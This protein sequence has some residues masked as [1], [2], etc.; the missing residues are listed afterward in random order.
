MKRLTF[1]EHFGTDNKGDLLEKGGALIKEIRE[2]DGLT[3]AQFQQKMQTNGVTRTI[4][5]GK[6]SKWENGKTLPDVTVQNYII[7]RHNEKQFDS[8]TSLEYG[9]DLPPIVQ[10][11]R[12]VMFSQLYHEALV[13]IKRESEIGVLSAKQENVDPNVWPFLTML[14]SLVHRSLGDN[15]SALE[16]IESPAGEITDKKLRDVYE[17]NRMG[18][19]FFAIQGI[20]DSSKRNQEYE[21]IASDLRLLMQRWPNMYRTW[22]ENLLRVYSR[23]DDEARFTALYEELSQRSE[24]ESL[25]TIVSNEEDDDFSNAREFA[26]MRKQAG[27][28]VVKSLLA[29]FGASLLA[30]SSAAFSPTEAAGTVTASNPEVAWGVDAS[31]YNKDGVVYFTKVATAGAD[32]TDIM[33]A[34][35]GGGWNFGGKQLVDTTDADKF[36]DVVMALGKS[37]GWNSIVKQ[38]ATAANPEAAAWG[39]D[40]S[41]YNKDGMVYFDTKGERVGG[42]Q[43]VDTDADKLIDFIIGNQNQMATVWGVDASEKDGMVYFDTKGAWVGGQQIVDTAYADITEL[44]A[45]GGGWN[46]G[47]KQLVDT[48]DAG[49]FLAALGGTAGQYQ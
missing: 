5:P 44:A 22:G 35:K 36:T 34:A 18:M 31:E 46:F 8:V 10:A 43:M 32:I 48:A 25:K 47:G 6:Q 28:T 1:S 9:F 21:S 20:A 12:N 2:G 13:F 24:P 4:D 27:F 41:E 49:A 38:A 29:L 33:M 30:L 15:E 26:V 40:A 37:V 17:L 7:S 11:I 14:E 45:K 39:V 42:Q 16:T 3:G 19:K 23:L